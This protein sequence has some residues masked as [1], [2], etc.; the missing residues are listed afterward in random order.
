MT[1]HYNNHEPAAWDPDRLAPDFEDR[2]HDIIVGWLLFP[3]PF[4][5][6]PA[7]TTGAKRVVGRIQTFM[8]MTQRPATVPSTR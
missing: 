1:R 4:V 8:P 5:G 6:I 3:F 7:V 2:G